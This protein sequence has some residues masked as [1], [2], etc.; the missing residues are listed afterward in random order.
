MCEFA[1]ILKEL[2]EEKGISQSELARNIGA[3]RS[4]IC[5]YEK[6]EISPDIKVAKK[7]ADTFGVTV[8]KLSGSNLETSIPSEYLKLAAELYKNN[9][10]VDK[11]RTMMDLLK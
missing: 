5:R 3:S 9:I 2:R 4:A 11:I 7:I 1:T 10:S 8:E 6:G